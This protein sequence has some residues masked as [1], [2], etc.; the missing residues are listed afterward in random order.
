MKERRFGRHNV[1]RADQLLRFGQTLVVKSWFY[2]LLC[3]FGN[4]QWIGYVFVRR[5]TLLI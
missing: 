1:G 4:V 5:R 2:I 3:I